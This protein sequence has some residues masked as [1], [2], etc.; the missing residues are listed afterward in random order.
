MGERPQERYEPGELDKTRKNLGRLTQEE[1]K[2]MSRLLGGEV[3]VEKADSSVEDRY[4][5]LKELNRR[6]ND[7]IAEPYQ[8]EREKQLDHPAADSTQVTGVTRE[9][10]V[11]KSSP[12]Y[13][14]SV[15]MAFLASR[16]EHGLVRRRDA[17]FI[18]FL[19]FVHRR[20]YI[21]PAF[22][23]AGDTIFFN[24]I[25]R[26]VLSV[27]SLLA[28]NR[29][30][31]LYR[32]KHGFYRTIMYTYRNWN[33][34]SIHIELSKL[35][36]RPREAFLK[37]TGT[38]FREIFKPFMIL[39][40]I[41][42]DTATEKALKHLFDL[43]LLSVPKDGKEARIIKELYFLARNE[44]YHI[45]SRIPRTCWPLLPY[46]TETGYD[47]YH[48][49]FTNRKD[50]ILS[51]LGLEEKDLILPPE[52]LPEGTQEE[53]ETI[54]GEEGEQ[55]EEDINAL[56]E[57]VVRHGL[58]ILSDLFPDS[59]WECPETWPDMIPYFKSICILPKGSDILSPED[60]IHQC[61]ILTALVSELCSGFRGMHFQKSGD[62]L[63]HLSGR[64]H[65]ILD[66]VIGK[67]Y[68]TPLTEY[69]RLLER[70]ADFRESQYAEKIQ[71]ELYWIK[72]N[73]LTPHSF[74][75]A[76]KGSRP[77][78]QKKLPKLHE[79]IEE[80]TGILSR[81]LISA[82][83]GTDPILE[84]PDDTFY[85]EVPGYVP[86]RV[87]AIFQRKKEAVSNLNLIKVIHGITGVLDYLVNNPE[88][89][90]YGSAETVYFREDYMNGCAPIYSVDSL[91]TANLIRSHDD[92]IR[93]ESEPQ[94]QEYFGNLK[95]AVQF[96]RD[97]IKNG[98][99]A[100][101]FRMKKKPE[102]GES[103]LLGTYIRRQ[104][105]DWIDRVFILREGLILLVLP[106][107]SRIDACNLA[108]RL[109]H[110]ICEHS[111]SLYSPAAGITFFSP[112]CAVMDIVN[113]GATA[114]GKALAA[115]GKVIVVYRDEEKRFEEK[116]L[117]L[118][119][120]ENEQN[121]V[122]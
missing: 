49:Y 101:T 102:P 95:D 116:N 28:R 36:S 3:G 10:A 33:I 50:E 80:I 122:E 106:E 68:I 81:L 76:F 119:P 83:E 2:K 18:L 35:Q 29:R 41:E 12:G 38:L 30:F 47:D 110:G 93:K 88:S 115:G 71:S 70:D 99:S 9:K 117:P 94:T 24:H 27:R 92:R 46:L 21:N 104:I 113:A 72:R 107:T 13:F 42:R 53:V 91:D 8:R 78:I 26:F 55:E 118:N 5:K 16:Q 79:A 77:A 100:I 120:S 87:K 14:A 69:C 58:D 51:F 59:G 73:Y 45:T 63:E 97:N 65:V 25:E 17:W 56:Q 43:T 111:E 11:S 4:R 67:Y 112:D 31:P 121:T 114:A 15:R 75:G 86:L 103:R 66:E 90:F 39:S 32:I 22:L 6:K 48:S 1:A 61:V 108:F 109:I 34:E 105:R 84:N 52:M 7:A 82:D 62:S 23:K 19:P 98:P 89:W 74:T 44:I 60:P 37:T 40:E 57:A 85:F 64:W 20:L 96:I 54:E